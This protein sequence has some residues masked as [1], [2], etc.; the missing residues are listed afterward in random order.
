MIMMIF[1]TLAI[2]A[3]LVP[4]IQRDLRLAVERQRRRAWRRAHPFA[5]A[6]EDAGIAMRRLFAAFGL[7]MEQAGR[8]L[9]KS[10]NTGTPTRAMERRR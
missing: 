1:A 3:G 9:A 8:N 10:M 6:L 2:A 5:A 7:S 4:L